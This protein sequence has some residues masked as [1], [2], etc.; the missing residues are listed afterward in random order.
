MT[1]VELLLAALLA[2]AATWAATWLVL[3]GLIRHGIYDTPNE[4][5]SHDQPKPRGG[6]LAVLA[7][8]LLSW[9]A[10][11]VL[12]GAEPPG[13]LVILAAGL[14]LAGVSWLDDVRSQSV[15]IRLIVQF[16][17]VAAGIAFTLPDAAGFLVFQGLLPAWLDHLIKALAW[18]WFIN[19]FN[20]MDGA[21]GITGVESF[22]IGLGL[23]LLLILGQ[24]AGPPGA[25]LA[26]AA[27]PLLLAACA[28]GFLLWNWAPSKIFLGDVG[29]VGLGYLIGW[30]L[31]VLAAEGNWAA[32]LLLP[33][34]YLC[35]ATL[36]LTRRALRGEKIWRGHREHFYQKAILRGAGHA[37][38]SANL[39]LHN[40]AL[41]LLA[42][43][44]GV[45]AGWIAVA[46]G[47]LVVIL[48]MFRYANYKAASRGSPAATE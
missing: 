38:V 9:L 27:Y 28:A 16:A 21:D 31:L 22:S 13:F 37:W 46:A 14:A 32:A 30:L 23:A 36:T 33:L 19:L 17:A 44:S 20:F 5:S 24:N 18:V 40:A 6:G 48:L 47:T 10:V 11:Y 26:S 42:L 43:A 39:M 34:Y 15:L 25:G 1:L 12:Y 4:R 3:R 2:A 8:L 35:D 45:F 29:S 41:I 7:V